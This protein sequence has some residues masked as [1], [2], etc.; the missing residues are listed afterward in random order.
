MDCFVPM[1]TYTKEEI[2]EVL[3]LHALYL[4]GDSNGKLCT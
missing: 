4:S 2:A 3:K 1:K